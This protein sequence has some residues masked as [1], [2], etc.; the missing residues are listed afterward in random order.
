M[1]REPVSSP[2]GDGGEQAEE[3]SPVTTSSCTEVCGK[4][5]DGKSCSKICL[6]TVYPKGHPEQKKRMYVM[7]D[8]PNCSKKS[9]T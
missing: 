1:A 8:A 6:V 7:L 3:N 4:G 9:W 5:L 2:E